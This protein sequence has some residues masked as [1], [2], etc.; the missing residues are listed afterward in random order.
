MSPRRLFYHAAIPAQIRNGVP[1]SKPLY[2][3]FSLQ[4]NFYKITTVIKQ[5]DLI[6]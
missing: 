5:T 2:N 1:Y 3:D 4:L 6:S